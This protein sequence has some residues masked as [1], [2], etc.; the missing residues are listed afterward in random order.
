MIPM[1]KARLELR[2]EGMHVLILDNPEKVCIIIFYQLQYFLSRLTW[3]TISAK[4]IIP[5]ESLTRILTY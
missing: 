1:D 4:Q 5:W 2:G 3:D